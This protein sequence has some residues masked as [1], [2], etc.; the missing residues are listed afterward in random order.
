MGRLCCTDE[1]LAT[2][3]TE[4]DQEKEREMER[5]RERESER[6]REVQSLLYRTCCAEPLSSWSFSLLHYLS[7]I[8]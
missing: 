6:E 3:L 5:E 7:L 8:L 1:D 2:L 4:G